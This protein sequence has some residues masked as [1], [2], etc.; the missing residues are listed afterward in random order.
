MVK[1]FPILT[2]LVDSKCP[3]GK[4]SYDML[5]GT[6]GD[7]PFFFYVVDRDDR[8]DDPIHVFMNELDIGT[9]TDLFYQVWELISKSMANAKDVFEGG[10]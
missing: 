6:F 8:C 10:E 1:I 4:E 9:F 7:V 3:V 2:T 5:I